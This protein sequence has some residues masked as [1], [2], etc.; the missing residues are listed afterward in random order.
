MSWWRWSGS[1]DANGYFKGEL[2]KTS[3]KLLYAKAYL[4]NKAGS[5]FD[6]TFTLSYTMFEK[7]ILNS[8][9]IKMILHEKNCNVL[10]LHDHPALHRRVV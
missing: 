10:F 2:C 3:N 1:L 7:K 6:L 4:T 8:C 5:D 9:D